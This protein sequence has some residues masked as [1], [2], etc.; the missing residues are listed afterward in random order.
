VRNVCANLLK[1]QNVRRGEEWKEI[2]RGIPAV[3]CG[4]GPSLAKSIPLLKKMSRRALFFAGGS[5]LNTLSFEGV[6]FHFGGSIDP[7]PPPYRFMRQTAF[8]IPF[9]YQNRLDHDFFMQVHGVKCCFGGGQSSAV[10]EW[11]LESLGLLLPPFDAG[12]N[13]S[14]FLT[15]VAAHL[16]CSPIIFV[17]MDFS[18]SKGEVYSKGVE[19]IEEGAEHKRKDPLAVTDRFGRR[20]YTRPD[21]LMGKKWIEAFCAAHPDIEFFDSTAAGLRIEGIPEE[22]LNEVFE[23]RLKKKIDLD[24]LIHRAVQTTSSFSVDPAIA[25][26]KIGMIEKS[27]KRCALLCEEL[28]VQLGRNRSQSYREEQYALQNVELEEELFYRTLLMPLWQVWRHLLEKGVSPYEKKLQEILFFKEV[29]K[30]AK[31]ALPI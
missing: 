7:K 12:W 30:H 16:G 1:S 18:K 29:L 28:F 25:R 14:T 23:N 10:E 4:A 31:R 22:T 20:V 21:F 9:F 11:L 15:H 27:M 26:E 3:I 5:A 19:Q 8:E 17:G 2:F 24:G 6:S 13:V